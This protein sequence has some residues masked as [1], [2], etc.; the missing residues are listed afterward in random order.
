MIKEKKRI[1]K[2]RLGNYPFLSLV[3]SVSL[4]L[5]LLGIFSILLISSFEIKKS[6]QENIELNIYLNK[7][8]SENE[9]IKIN[10]IILSKK[11]ILNNDE[12]SLVF[13]SK[14]E[15]A[16]DYSKQLGEDFI[17]FLGKNPLRDLL[18][19]K[20]NPDF[21]KNDQLETIEKD[22]MKIN[23]IYEVIYPRDLIESINNNINK[24]GTILIGIFFI[25]FFISIILINNTIK[26]A[27]FS[28]RFLIRSMQLVGATS[29]FIQKPFLIRGGLYGA[30]SGMLASF[31]LIG[32]LSFLNSKMDNILSIIDFNKLL[33]ISLSIIF[34]GILIVVLSTYSSVNKYLRS[35]L[36]DLY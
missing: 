19:L 23:G 17:K 15:A 1:K 12:S 33:I 34:I 36:E 21:L 13:I 27:L 4:C 6:I 16:Q 2:K 7:G 9:I 25:L 29:M 5:L 26:L 30:I 22:I 14:E 8:I 35:S 31:F 18:I 10:K 24:I 20:V 3:F 11:Y 32:L 28:Q